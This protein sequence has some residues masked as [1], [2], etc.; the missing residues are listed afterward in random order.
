MAD[1]HSLRQAAAHALRNVSDSVAIH[2]LVAG[3]GAADADALP[4]IY[5]VLARVTG[6]ATDPSL[7][8]GEAGTFWREWLLAH[9]EQTQE[10]WYFAAFQALE[11]TQYAG[12][13][14]AVP[15]AELVPA[16]ADEAD[17]IR[18]IADRTLK[19]R[20]GT[21]SPSEGWTVARRQRFWRSQL[22]L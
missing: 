11:Y 8:A 16:L 13:W 5:N 18:F 14:R 15:L 9:H 22:G 7:S 10:E 17:H 19:A 4:E 6:V 20:S 21:W 3:V 12:E 1:G 2:E